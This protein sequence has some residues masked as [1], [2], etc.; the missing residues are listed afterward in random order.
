M[1]DDINKLFK[2]QWNT[3]NLLCNE[4]FEKGD[5]S[6][7]NTIL[8]EIEKEIHRIS[9]KQGVRNIQESLDRHLDNIISRLREQLPGLDNNDVT[10]LS[11]VYAGFSPRAICLFT[12]YT[13]KYYYKKRAVLKE[14]LLSSDAPDRLFFAE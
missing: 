3:L 10:F 13:I 8:T 5:S 7:K 2:K 14:R 1:K 9:G 6:L 4:Y 11:F 12:G